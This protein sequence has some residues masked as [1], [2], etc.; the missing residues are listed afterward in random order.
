MAEDNGGGGGNAFLGVIVGALLIAVVALGFF[1][2][3]G[4]MGS[5][6][7]DI[8]IEAPEAPTPG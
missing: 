7:A 5:Q 3:N 6:S 8:S 1:V 4:G 2:M